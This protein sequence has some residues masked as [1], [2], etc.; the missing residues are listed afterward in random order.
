MHKI[1]SLHGVN[2]HPSEILTVGRISHRE[3]LYGPFHPRK[4]SS[5]AGLLVGLTVMG[6]RRR[7]EKRM[8][9]RRQPSACII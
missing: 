3:L 9:L 6:H 8:P 5:A 4:M 2:Y 7:S 1:I